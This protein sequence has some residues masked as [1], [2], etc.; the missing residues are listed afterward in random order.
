MGRMEQGT[1]ERQN[2]RTDGMDG[3]NGQTDQET[4]GAIS[5][6]DEGTEERK[7]RGDAGTQ[8]RTEKT[9]AAKRSASQ[10]LDLPG[11]RALWESRALSVTLQ[12]LC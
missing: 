4:E 2:G 9:R 7:D 5:E 6:G 10:R 11:G 12:K 1:E 8:E 3:A